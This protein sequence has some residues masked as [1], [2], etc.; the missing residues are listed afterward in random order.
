MRNLAQHPRDYR[1]Q[2]A[3]SAREALG[4]HP[5]ELVDVL[6]DQPIERRVSPGRVKP[7]RPITKDAI[8][9]YIYGVF[10]GRLGRGADGPPHRL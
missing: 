9:H 6:A 7:K 2:R 8:F 4:P 10:V 1:A 3:V 5:Q